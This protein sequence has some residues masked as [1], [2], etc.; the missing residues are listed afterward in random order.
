[1]KK[2]VGVPRRLPHVLQA[3]QD[4]GDSHGST[5]RQIMDHMEN[6]QFTTSG[7]PKNLTTEA[8]RAVKYAVDNGLVKEKAGRLTVTSFY[9]NKKSDPSKSILEGRRRRKKRGRRRRRH[10]RR[11]GSMSSVTDSE[12]SVTGDE[13][14]TDRDRS[15]SRSRSRSPEYT[16]DGI[17][18]HRHRRKRHGRRRRRRGRRHHSL[19]DREAS[20]RGDGKALDDRRCLAHRLEDCDNPGCQRGVKDRDEKLNSYIN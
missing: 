3:I 14:E 19:N 2:A 1:M 16:S 12:A 11:H 8:R 9:S 10:H 5:M 7:R 17:I 20:P 15:H 18:S 6:A 4:L 13:W